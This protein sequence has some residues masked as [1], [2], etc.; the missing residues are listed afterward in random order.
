MSYFTNHDYHRRRPGLFSYILVALIGAVV[1]GLLVLFLAPYFYPGLTEVPQIVEDRKEDLP[2]LPK[3]EPEDTAIVAISKKVGP[4]VV[5]ITN[6][7]GGDFFDNPITS[8][9]SGVIIDSQKGY[10]VTNFH[11]IEGAKRLVVTLDKEHQY[12]AKIVGSD[13]ET[14]L[15]VIRIDA[16]GLPEAKLGDSTKLQVGEL[17]VAIGNPLGN[18]F[19]RTVT[20]GVISALNREISLPGVGPEITLEVIQ[21]DAAINPGNSGGALVN[22]QG[23]VIGIN[24]SKIARADVEGMGFAIPISDAKPIIRQLI[25]KGKVIRPF[26]GV[27]ELVTITEKMSKWYDI[28]V[29]VYVGGVFPGGPADNAGM[30]PKDVIVAIAGKNISSFKELKKVLREHKVG[31]KITVTV[32]RRNKKIQLEIVLAEKP[33]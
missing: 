7:K 11:V 18:E 27:Y 25:E 17:A 13:A 14:D 22:G 5:G 4:A 30:Y 24:S 8:T 31:D 3:W 28:P 2:P 21:T 33:Q 26:L 20:V 32:V 12:E 10:I 6:F 9:G 1:G 15:A 29:G 16:K 23:E 19:A